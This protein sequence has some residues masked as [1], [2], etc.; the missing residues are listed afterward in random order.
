[1]PDIRLRDCQNGITRRVNYGPG[2][3]MWRLP[4]SGGY[5]QGPASTSRAGNV[6]EPLLQLS[7]FLTLLAG[8][9]YFTTCYTSY[10][11]SGC[12][13]LTAALNCATDALTHTTRSGLLVF[14]GCGCIAGSC[15]FPPQMCKHTFTWWLSLVL[16]IFFRISSNHYMRAAPS[17]CRCVDIRL[18]FA[19]GQSGVNYNPLYKTRSKLTQTLLWREPAEGQR[20]LVRI[21]GRKIAPK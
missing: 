8:N 14:V 2:F 16:F 7:D 17:Q 18:E 3:K 19:D 6:N 15:S 5:P 9:F 20:Q 13:R 1:M 11:V 10:V 21:A 12:L 4:G